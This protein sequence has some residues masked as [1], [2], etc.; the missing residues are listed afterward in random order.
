MMGAWEQ[1]RSR[2]KQ[3]AKLL[4]LAAISG[5]VVRIKD[6]LSS[7]EQA[8][9]RLTLEVFQ[10]RLDCTYELLDSLA[11]LSDETLRQIKRTAVP[12]E[13]LS[14]YRK[15]I[16]TMHALAQDAEKLADSASKITPEDNVLLQ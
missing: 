6:F 16:E 1:W 8:M 4:P 12:V 13:I 5:G 9:P 10:T 7:K 11:L 14:R 3:N 15:L 2:P